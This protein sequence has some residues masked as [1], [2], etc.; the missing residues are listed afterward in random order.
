MCSFMSRLE[1]RIVSVAGISVL[2]C[3]TNRHEKFNALSCIIFK[4]SELNQDNSFL[5]EDLS[6][7][8]SVNF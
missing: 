1:N 7:E 6:S 5:T 2:W 4:K 3:V 8:Y